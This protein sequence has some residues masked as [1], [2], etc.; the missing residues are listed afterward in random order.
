MSPRQRRSATGEKIRVVALVDSLERPGGG[1][2]LALEGVA[3]LD[4]E[5]F[6]RTLCVTR[7]REEMAGTPSVAACVARLEEAGV[8]MLPLNRSSRLAVWAFRPLLARL[9]ESDVV[10]G[11]MFG[12]NVWA[13][14]LGRVAGVPAIVAHEHMWGYTG[15]R[16]RSLVDR[17]LIARLSDA[18]IAVSGEGRRQM[19]ETERIPPQDIVLLRNGIETLPRVDRGA[20]R[21]ALGLPQEAQVVGSVGHLRG[22][23][24]FEV[25]IAAAASARG[26]MPGLRVIIAGEG[27]ERGRL[28]ELISKLGLSQTVDLLGERDDVATVLGAC[29]VAV[30]CSD[31]EGGPLSVME[32]MDAGLPVI[33]SDVGGLPELVEDG[34]TGVL[35]P[36][37]EPAAIARALA[38]LLGDPELRSRMGE[39]ARA[40][41]ER[42]YDIDSWARALERLYER[43]LRN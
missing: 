36:P 34:V 7:W 14:V 3:R 27:P 16:T 11:H 18:F 28:E 41:R 6:E 31:F 5:R 19:I 43:L 38:R 9:R 35:V 12:S 24:A 13:S 4:P 26:N 29:D 21:R 23:K 32:Y 1:E 25:L 37:R 15:G 10:H 2:R 33:A 42:D 8:T 30:C 20:A 39:E 40:R 17:E 22:E